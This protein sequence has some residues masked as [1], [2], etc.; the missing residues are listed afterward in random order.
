[1]WNYVFFIAYLKFKD[2]NEYNGIE[3]YVAGK[4]K[5]GDIQWLP[6]NQYDFLWVSYI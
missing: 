4:L 6:I 3:S 5:D 2:P 1:M